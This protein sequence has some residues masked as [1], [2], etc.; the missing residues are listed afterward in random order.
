MSASDEEHL[1]RAHSEGRVLITKDADFLRI[2]NAG[3]DHSGIL[4]GRQIFEVLDADDMNGM[5][6]YV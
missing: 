4:F 2:H 6:E 3:V 1:E 5:V